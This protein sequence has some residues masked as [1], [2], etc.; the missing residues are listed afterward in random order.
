MADADA[1]GICDD[2][3]ECVGELDE[4]GICNGPGA[5]YE[6]GCSDIPEGD[7]DCNGNQLDA[8]GVCGG[9]CEAD[10]DADGICDDVDDC[11]GAYDECGICNG[12]GAIYECGC[13]DVPEGDC[14]CDG[15]QL[16]ALGVCGGD[17][18]ADADA[19]GICD[20]V[21]DCVGEYDALGFC[22]GGCEADVDDDGVCD[23]EEIFGCQ[24]PA[25][26][27]FDATATEDDGNCN[28]DSEAPEG[29][30]VT[31][32]P[33]SATL[34]GQVTVEGEVA[35]GLDWIGAFGSDGQC[36][37]STSLFM[38]QGLAY[39]NLTI[40]GDDATTFDVV[41]GISADGLFAL[42]FY[43]QSTGATLEYNE[44]VLLGGWFNT[45]GAPLPGYNNP[46]TN[47]DFGYPLCGDETACNYDPNSTTNDGCEYAEE[48]YQCDGTCVADEDEDGVCDLF[49]P[50]VGI[51][52]DCGVCNGPGAIYDCGCNDILEGECDCQGN[53]LDALF[54]CGGDCEADE[55][56]DNIC[57]D[58]DDCVG[59]YDA[60]GI[61]NGPGAVYECGCSDIPAG[62]CDC[63]GNQL[64]ALGVCGGDCDADANYNGICDDEE[65]NNECIGDFNEDG[66][67]Q[68]TD[69]LDFLQKYGQSCDDCPE[70]INEDGLVQLNDLLDLLSAYGVICDE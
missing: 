48:G 60:C 53:V 47:Y 35:M 41:E 16:D 30:E 27:N 64:D 63:D 43:D 23:S 38:Y 42:K 12:P 56:G 2:E 70:D 44:G 59:E 28:Y 3:D 1:D 58:E 49:D 26:L 68:L 10:A 20:D 15:N 21:D 22:N 66:I 17:C 67:V 65:E 5:I 40:Y 55:D 9:D 24:D 37:G 52:D 11:V 29:F 14:D 62:D 4:C 34:F 25:A 18:A 50:C 57:D 45:N 61:C 6:C 8:L 36:A 32:T 39:I 46:Q 69:L 51:V 33:N 54:T 19:D 31:P 7:C 13:S